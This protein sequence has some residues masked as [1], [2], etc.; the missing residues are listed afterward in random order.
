MTRMWFAIFISGVSLIAGNYVWQFMAHHN[1]AEANE[2]S[3][4]QAM[5]LLVVGLVLSLQRLAP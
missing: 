4:F 2:R 5:A 3:F 1:W